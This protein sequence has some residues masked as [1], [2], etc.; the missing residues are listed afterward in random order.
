MHVN[1][2][3]AETNQKLTSIE[4]RRYRRKRNELFLLFFVWKKQTTPCVEMLLESKKSVTR[5]RE[6]L[7]ARKQLPDLNVVDTLRA[8]IRK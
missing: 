1:F 2:E 5:S 8:K 4:R 6:Y 7:C 3:N